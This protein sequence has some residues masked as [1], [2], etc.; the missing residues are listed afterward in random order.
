MTKTALYDRVLE[1]LWLSAIVLTPIMFFPFGFL[2][3]ELPKIAL[4]RSLVV[5]MLFIYVLK[6]ILEKRISWPSFDGIRQRWFWIFFGGFVLSVIAATL[7]S[8]APQVSFWGSYFRQS[9]FISFLSYMVFFLLLLLNVRKKEQFKRIF[10]ALLGT[11]SVVA[12]IGILQKF[13]PA[14]S[15]FWDV[16]LFLGRIFSTLGHPNYLAT[17]FVLIFPFTFALFLERKDGSTIQNSSLRK[18]FS[19]VLFVLMFFA[20]LLTEGRAGILAFVV[21]FFF[22]FIFYGFMA[23]KKWLIW[24]AVS[25]PVILFLMALFANVFRSSDVVQK[26]VLNRALLESGN[27]RSIET[28]LV[29]WPKVVEMIKNR[30]LL[31][32]GPETFPIAFS[33]FASPKLLDVENMSD[34]ADRAH[35]EFLDMAS[36]VG[37]LGLIFYAGFIVSLFVIGFSII[38]KLSSWNE[39]LFVLAA[40]TGIISLLTANQFG[41]SVSAHYVYFWLI[42]ALILLLSRFDRSQ[43]SK[44]LQGLE[45]LRV[46]EKEISLPWLRSQVVIFVVVFIT[47]I[48]SALFIYFWNVRPVAADY[49]FEKSRSTFVLEDRLNLLN[50]A[51]S[52][53]PHQNYYRFNYFDTVLT[54]LFPSVAIEEKQHVLQLGKSLLDQANTYVSGKDG[55][56]YFYYGRLYTAYA[57]YDQLYFDEAEKSFLK[58]SELSPIYP[59]IYLLWGDMA[60]QKGDYEKAVQKYEKFLQLSPKYWQWKFELDKKTP[61]EQDKYRIFYKLNP[62]FNILFIQLGRMYFLAGD[63][64]KALEYLKYADES[65]DLYSTLSV[66]YG[67]SGEIDKALEAIQTGLELDPENP[68]LENNLKILQ[69]EKEKKR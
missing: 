63:K 40:L 53:N 38:K 23:H 16:D 22:F 31:G 65:A 55:L 69:Q 44:I 37:F 56:V 52:L 27:L 62:N 60:Q 5:V 17:Y 67:K 33:A 30:P 25:V 10:I 28:R 20:L 59:Y 43:I 42:A 13:V 12:L 46:T 41:F 51:L 19:G 2:T 15:G 7:F 57:Q 68:V 48:S 36:N 1:F 39:K 45:E 49:Y 3:F 50:K 9:G 66:I 29:M 4:F 26:T 61:E 32:Y 14:F 24:A 8:I 35:N 18:I 58:A 54:S 47:G 64:E 34:I 6:V 11:A 21:G